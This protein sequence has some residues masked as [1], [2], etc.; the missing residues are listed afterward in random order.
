[1]STSLTVSEETR[2][3]KSEKCRQSVTQSLTE[4]Y[5]L[6]AQ[7]YHDPMTGSHC[8]ATTKSHVSPKWEEISTW[9]QR[10]VVG[11]PLEIFSVF[12]C[13]FN[14]KT[15]RTRHRLRRTVVKIEKRNTEKTKN[16][17]TRKKRKK[18][19][20]ILLPRTQSTG[21]A[22]RSLATE[23]GRRRFASIYIYSYKSKY[24]C[25]GPPSVSEWV[26]HGKFY[27]K[28]SITKSPKIVGTDVTVAQICQICS[29]LQKFAQICQICSNL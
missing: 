25:V 26:R 11:M 29:N 4:T 22:Y 6:L 23:H 5:L 1:M 24:V 10:K 8:K 16:M 2:A 20:I 17:K 28:D 15:K 18:G 9:R 21:L 13:F 12:S 3:Q 14:P 27:N 7:R 19:E